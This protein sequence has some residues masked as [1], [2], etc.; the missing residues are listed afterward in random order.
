MPS[1]IHKRASTK[2]CSPTNHVKFAPSLPLSPNINASGMWDRFKTEEV[3]AASVAFNFA[4]D[5]K[6]IASNRVEYQTDNN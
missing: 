6:K 5:V 2:H 1:S 3:I 4:Y